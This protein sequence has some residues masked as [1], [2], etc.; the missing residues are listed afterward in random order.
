MEKQIEEIGKTMCRS[1]GTDDCVPCDAYRTCMIHLCAVDVYKAGYRKASDVARE[2][3]EEVDNFF[4]KTIDIFDKVLDK[5]V[6]AGDDELA[7]FYGD[8][9]NLVITLKIALAE[10]KKKYTEDGE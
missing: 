7:Y 1:F 5:A 3:F 4:I 2:I 9:K 8:E 10:L 6:R